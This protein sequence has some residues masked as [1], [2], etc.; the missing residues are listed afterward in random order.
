MNRIKVTRSKKIGVSS[1]IK[2]KQTDVNVY[3][4]FKQMGVSVLVIKPNYSQVKCSMEKLYIVIVASGKQRSSD[5]VNPTMINPF[6]VLCCG[7]G[8]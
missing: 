7:G 3:I 1:H 4:E 5:H 2:F 8:Y 6:D